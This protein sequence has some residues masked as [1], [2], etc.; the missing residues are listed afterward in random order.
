MA[1]RRPLPIAEHGSELHPN[2][3]RVYQPAERTKA[4]IVVDGISNDRARTS[5]AFGGL[6][7]VRVVK[8]L[9]GPF[10]LNVAEVAVPFKLDNPGCPLA[11]EWQIR[12]QAEGN[13]DFRADASQSL[14]GFVR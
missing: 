6:E 4:D 5:T 11:A 10:R 9:E 1:F 12:E 7:P 13:D 2:H 8:C 3:G 14:N